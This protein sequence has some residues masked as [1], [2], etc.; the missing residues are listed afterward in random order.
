[1]N[2]NFFFCRIIYRFVLKTKMNKI[3]EK[4][5]QEKDNSFLLTQ[6]CFRFLFCSFYIY[7]LVRKKK[8]IDSSRKGRRFTLSL[9]YLSFDLFLCLKSVW[10]LNVKKCCVERFL[11]L[12]FFFPE[13]KFSQYLI[14]PFSFSNPSKNNFFSSCFLSFFSGDPGLSLSLSLPKKN[15]LIENL[16][17]KCKNC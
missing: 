4:M 1:M 10:M 2:I 16:K 12:E 8:F 14:F 6:K 11:I 13:I 7:R 5:K 15:S 9:I 3:N 17:E